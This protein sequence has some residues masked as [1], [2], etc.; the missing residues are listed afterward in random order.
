MVGASG[1]VNGGCEWWCQWWVRVVVS[2]VGAS[3]GVN[4]G[5]EWWCQG[6][7]PPL[8]GSDR[9][10]FQGFDILSVSKVP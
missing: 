6:Q 9:R 2:M 10:H 1:G 8:S 4:G 7:W 5:C 3:G